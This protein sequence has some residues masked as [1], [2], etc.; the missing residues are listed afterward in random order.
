MILAYYGEI[1]STI[2]TMSGRGIP[3]SRFVQS[4]I[5]YSD[6]R[7][8]PLTAKYKA[9]WILEIDGPVRKWLKHRTLEFPAIPS[10]EELTFMILGAKTW[11]S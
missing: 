1:G 6:E 2:T 8:M 4:I 10:E 11:K 9:H 3:V 5:S 7:T